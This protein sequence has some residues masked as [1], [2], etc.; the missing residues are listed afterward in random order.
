MKIIL[1]NSTIEM[2]KNVPSGT[3][4]E[5]FPDFANSDYPTSGG[6]RI[7]PSAGL[8]QVAGWVNKSGVSNIYPVEG[9]AKV[10]V[11]GA[12]GND[13]IAVA[14]FF[15]SSAATSGNYPLIITSDG[16]GEI[17]IPSGAV[18][19]R[20]GVSLTGGGNVASNCRYF[21]VAE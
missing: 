14:A 20:F 1:K 21:M 18:Y 19:V 2:Q 7:N 13:A 15:P 17:N 10:K 8:S 3:E 11:T 12:V 16:S 5:F 4:V 9:Y 6:W